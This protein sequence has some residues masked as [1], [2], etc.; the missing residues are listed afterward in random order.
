M[1]YN[2]LQLQGLVWV[3]HAMEHV[4]GRFICAP[5]RHQ[6][7]TCV[8]KLYESGSKYERAKN[9]PR[10]TRKHKWLI[11]VHIYK[12]YSVL[13]ADVRLDYLWPHNSVKP[14]Q[15][16]SDPKMGKVLVRKKCGNCMALLL[17]IT[18]S[19]YFQAIYF[20]KQLRNDVPLLLYKVIVKINHQ[21]IVHLFIG[22]QVLV[23]VL[24]LD[25]SNPNFC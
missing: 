19:R 15:C 12:K 14:M 22:P 5:L 23:S 11:P 20:P 3:I 7:L 18:I 1:N 4:A 9:F 10:C 2:H 6:Q 21:G 13:V 25:A 16:H 17:T 24:L 8:L